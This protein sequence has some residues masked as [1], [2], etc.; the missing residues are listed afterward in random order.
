[1]RATK[2]TPKTLKN[3]NKLEYQGPAAPSQRLM[4]AKKAHAE[5]RASI[6]PNALNQ[7]PPMADHVYPG[8]WAWPIAPVMAHALTKEYI[9]VF[10]A[11]KCD[12]VG[13]RAR[14]QTYPR[15]GRK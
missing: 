1:M 9:L 4:H 7:F 8:R 5:L 13:P 6:T 10:S 12:V 3:T 2:S 14:A 15:A 11:L